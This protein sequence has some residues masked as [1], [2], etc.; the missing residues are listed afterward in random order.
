M[1]ALRPMPGLDVGCVD[2]K[3]EAIEQDGDKGDDGAGPDGQPHLPTPPGPPVP[4]HPPLLHRRPRP[5][6]TLQG[7]EREARGIVRT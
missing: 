6:P 5:L 3:D 7:G 2:V 1:N 4:P